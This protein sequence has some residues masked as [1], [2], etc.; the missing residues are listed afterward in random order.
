MHGIF[1]FDSLLSRER[2]KQLSIVTGLLR[3]ILKT[4]LIFIQNGVGSLGIEGGL[5]GPLYIVVSS[6]AAVG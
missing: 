3:V 6:D 4:F 2:M 1:L 5:D